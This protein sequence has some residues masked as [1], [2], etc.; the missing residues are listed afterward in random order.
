MIPQKEVRLR[1]YK[2]KRLI[3]N[4]LAF[5]NLN[6]LY[7]RLSAFAVEQQQLVNNTSFGDSEN[8]YQSISSTRSMS[9]HD[10]I[11]Y[12]APEPL[13]TFVINEDRDENG[14]SV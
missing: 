1:I 9:R 12:D 13:G 14:K 4:Y 11:F 7:K 3:K 2:K 10:S 8:I 6:N 5:D